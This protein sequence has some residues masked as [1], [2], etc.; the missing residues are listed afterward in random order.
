MIL[1]TSIT[2]WILYSSNDKGYQWL[3]PNESTPIAVVMSIGNLGVNPKN[4]ESA[5]VYIT[6][7]LNTFVIFVIFLM[8]IAYKPIQVKVIQKVDEINISPGDFAVMI[9]NIP[10][11]KTKEQIKEWLIEQEEGTICD[12]NLCYDI[13]EPIEK[14]KKV[15]KLKKI[16]A[17]YDELT[18][19]KETKREIE[20]K[21]KE[22]EEDVDQIKEKLRSDDTDQNFTGKAFV[23]Y[24][25][26][27]D[28]EN[29]TSKFR[30]SW[31]SKLHNFITIKI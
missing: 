8:N 4:Y 7:A 13:K 11:N 16:L 22:L 31:L 2:G 20:S 14:L 30:Q 9:S 25:Q 10:T 3:K 17:N 27:S 23:I 19:V 15:E 21:I 1:V 6:C 5:D 29:L 12:I 24:N 26:Q 28:I 18:D